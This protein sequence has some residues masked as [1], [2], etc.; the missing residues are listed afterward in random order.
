MTQ[1]RRLINGDQIY[2]VSKNWSKSTQSEGAVKAVSYNRGKI[3]R[4]NRLLMQINTQKPTTS[5]ITITTTVT[6]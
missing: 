4:L 5:V 3:N 2:R 1:G 6:N